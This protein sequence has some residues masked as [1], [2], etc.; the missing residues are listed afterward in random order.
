MRERGTQ[1]PTRNQVWP[2]RRLDELSE[3][4]AGVTLGD[5]PT[6]YNSV[7]L[8]YLRVAN[9]QDGHIDLSEVKT[10]RVLRSQVDRYR[11]RR[12]DVLVT[13]GGDFDKVGRGALWDGQIPLCIHQN[14]IFRVRC[15]TRRLS[16]GYLAAYMQSSEARRYFLAAV[17]RTAIGSIDLPQLQ[18][19]PLPL[20]PLREQQ[21]IEEILDSV[22]EEITAATSL[23]HKLQRIA[24]SVLRQ[25]FGKVAG[26]T[27][28]VIKEEFDISSGITLGQHRRPQNRPRPYLRVANVQRGWIDTSKLALLEASGRD[29]R[30]W[31]LRAYDLLIVEGHASPDEIGRCALVTSKTA[32]LL[33]QNHLFRL[34][35]RSVL[36]E[37]AL[38]WLNSDFMRSYWR[39]RCATSSGLYTINSKL[40]ACA[41]M[42]LVSRGEQDRFVQ[43]WRESSTRLDRERQSIARL[44]LLKQGLMEDLLT[45]KVRLSG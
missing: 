25:K 19:M 30:R 17:K 32:G 10:V 35:P 6:G 36:P 12:G 40:L 41:P 31:S 28:T 26:R 29:E 33:Y 13:E 3:I 45:G 39:T 38:L 16:S 44:R 7:A 9:V 1:A 20:P 11:L 18:Q 4:Y 43:M 8:P 15:D 42:P 14:H 2:S 24:E 22:D 27:Q 34:R 37:F 23:V 21:R 5:E